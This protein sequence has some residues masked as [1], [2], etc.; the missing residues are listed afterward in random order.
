MNG[1]QIL[2]KVLAAHN[3]TEALCEEIAASRIKGPDFGREII[4]TDT[5]WKT[6]ESRKRKA[7]FHFWGSRIIYRSQKPDKCTCE[8]VAIVE[9]EDGQIVQKHPEQVQFLN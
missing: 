3:Q 5:N 4:I 8:T 9:L 1:K 7:K 6:K 2:A